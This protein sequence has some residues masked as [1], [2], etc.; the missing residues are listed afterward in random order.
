MPLKNIPQQQARRRI[1]FHLKA[2]K[3]REVILGGTLDRC[4]DCGSRH[5][6]RDENG[7]WET[8]LWLEPGTYEFRFLVDGKWLCS[9][10]NEVVSHPCGGQNRVQVVT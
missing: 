1:Y 9:P 5:L 6:K 4:W 2:P 3:A 10:E 8:H 7:T